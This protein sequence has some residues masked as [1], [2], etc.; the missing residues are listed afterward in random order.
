[1][2]VSATVVPE[3]FAVSKVQ[4]STSPLGS[5]AVVVVAD[6]PDVVE[7][8]LFEVEV[9]DVLEFVD[10]VELVEELELEVLVVEDVTGGATV[11]TLPPTPK[12]AALITALGP[13]VLVTLNFT[14][15]EMFQ[16]T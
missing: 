3:I 10:V 13:P 2:E 14:C 7:V 1:L 15:P 4:W 5:I 9:L 8:E 16:T 12:N 6:D 11:G